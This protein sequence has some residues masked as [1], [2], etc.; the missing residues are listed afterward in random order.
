MSPTV[1]STARFEGFDAARGAAMVLVCLSHFLGTYVQDVTRLPDSLGLMTLIASP[2][3]IMLS[4][5]LVGMLTSDRDV[6]SQ[7]LRVKLADRA[8]FL[9]IIGH[10]LLM[11]A[12]YRHTSEMHEARW[13]GPAFITDAI[14]VSILVSLWAV[15]QFSPFRRAIM[16]AALYAVAWSL[17][18]S[19]RPNGSVDLV[20]QETFFGSLAPRYFPYCWPLAPWVGVYLMWTAFGE[21]IARQYRANDVAGAERILLRTTVTLG[22]LAVAWYAISVIPHP[23]ALDPLF[24]RRMKFPPGPLYLMFFGSLGVGLLWVAHVS[25]RRKWVEGLMRAAGTV[26]RCSLAVFIAQSFLYFQGLHFLNLRY[27]PY[28]PVFFAVSL[29]PLYLLAK[30]WDDRQWNVHL[31]VG[32]TALVR[33]MNEAPVSEA[34]WRGWLPSRR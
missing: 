18:L 32:L 15:R 8:L 17:I 1:R 27:T 14:A 25:A 4:G 10:P 2:T 22:V 19:W 16:G 12:A 20:F 9:I 7:A 29:V 30:V 21:V 3:F 13:F 31:S 6:R 33:R 5:V 34:T 28:W 23:A 11:A 26:G 24:L